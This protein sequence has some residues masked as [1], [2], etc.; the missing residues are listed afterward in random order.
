[1]EPAVTR[2]Q[3]GTDVDADV[4]AGVIPIGVVITAP[5]AIGFHAVNRVGNL[6]AVVAVTRGFVVNAG[7]IVFETL[8]TGV[9]IVGLRADRRSDG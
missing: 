1:V 9:A 7:A 5:L 2:S 3:L 6:W 4:E 8:M